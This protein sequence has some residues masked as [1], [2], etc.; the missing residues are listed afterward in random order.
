[1]RDFFG[2][3]DVG[4]G[5][6][7]QV[8]FAADGTTWNTAALMSM[9]L[10]GTTAGETLVGYATADS[11]FGGDGADVIYGRDGSDALSGDP[12]ADALVGENGNDTLLG[13]ADNDSLQGGNGDDVLDGG[14]GNDLLAGG[15]YDTWNGNYTGYGSDTYRFGVGGGQD[16]IFD[17]N[18]AV[19]EIDTIALGAGVGTSDVQLLRVNTND[20]SVE[21]VGT[22]DKI[23]VSSHFNGANAGD[24][25]IELIRFADGTVWDAARIAAS[26]LTTTQGTAA[27]ETLN[28]GTGADRLLGL[29]GNDTLNGNAGNDWLDGG[30]GTDTMR[31]GAGDDVYVVDA[32]ADSV[33]ENASEGTDTVR[34]SV[35][36]TLGA[37]V[38]HL[39]LTGTAAINGT[40]NTLANDLYGNSAA[41][42]LAGG[43][44]NDRYYVGAGDTVTE[45]NN[46]G[47]DAVFSTTTWTLGTNIEHLTLLG[48]TA[49]NGTGNTLANTLTGNDAANALNGG[50]GADTM[51]GGLGDDTY[52]VDTA[53]DIVTEL[54]DQ[55]IDR[56]N[57]SVAHTLG[58]NVENLTLTGSSGLAGTGN[59]LDN[60]IV[61]NSGAN[62][63]SGGA[64]ND[65][66]DGGT[67]NDTMNGGTGDDTFVVNAAGD[68][69]NE[70]AGEGT[71]TVES[72]VTR[73]LGANFENL[74]LTGTSAINGTGNTDANVLTGNGA[75]NTLTGGEGNDTYVGGAGN[76][77]LNDTSTSSN[78]V[79]RWGIGQGNDTITDAGGTDRIEIGAGVTASQVT[80]T[81][82]TNDLRVTLT[83]AS[84]VLTI[85]NW[86]TN[87]ANRIEEI[88]LA[89]GSTV[90]AGTAAPLSAAPSQSLLTSTREASANRTTRIAAATTTSSSGDLERSVSLLVQSM[91]QFRDHTALG[92][93]LIQRAT[94]A[95]RPGV[96]LASPL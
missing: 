85:K 81:R 30:L 12:G 54:L 34:A 27:A 73:T 69:V 37:N 75:A 59:A 32:T 10:V 33:T 60:V 18:G 46:A 17:R 61:G 43:A 70:N 62:T 77:T 7:D 23:T 31:G 16:T 51:I 58:S 48:A 91:S 74:T 11:I 5:A 83:G 50:T 90:N 47:T 1:V 41:N 8:R 79:Y 36:W 15:I 20:L 13:G 92:E 25:A 80:L 95:E 55:G 9:V 49:I 38:E 44:G 84:D 66:L 19:G 67:G 29:D 72:L 78:E 45:G 57:S 28:G 3:Q 42:T 26:A 56:V 71:D 21:L 88:R 24:G 64:G 14:T 22:T 65:R 76:D 87:T 94:F 2:S 63:L 39:V 82:S 93:S 4:S 40:G 96:N 68:V 89:D 86:Y 35:T 6:I 52:T 53:G